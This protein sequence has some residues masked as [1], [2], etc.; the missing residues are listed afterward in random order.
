MR[1][2]WV[3]TNW[4]FYF[5]KDIHFSLWMIGVFKVDMRV[6]QFRSF[7]IECYVVILVVYDFRLSSIFLMVY[8]SSK[9]FT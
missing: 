2:D 9:A 7:V 6:S 1:E 3:L 4:Y 5:N 8:A